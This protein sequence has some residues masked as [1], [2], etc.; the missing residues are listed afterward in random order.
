ML[1]QQYDKVWRWID[2]P[3]RDGKPDTGAC[4]DNCVNL[5]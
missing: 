1:S 3:G 5:G 2:W 4:Q